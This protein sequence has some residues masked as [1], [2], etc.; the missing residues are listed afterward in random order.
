[1]LRK[2]F[3]ISFL[4]FAVGASAQ[5]EV[6]Y[7]VFQRS[8]FDSNGD[9]AGDLK[10]IQQ[11][12]D[13]LQM[14]GVNAV[15]LSPVYQSDNFYATDWNKTDAVYGSFGE[16]RALVQEAHRRKMKLYQD[17][18]LRF[19]TSKHIWFAEKDKYKDY[20]LL[21]DST[22]KDYINDEGEKDQA[23]SV[24]FKK[25]EV[26]GEI[27]K[28]LQYWIN[29]EGVSSYYS[30]VDGFRFS[31]VSD[32]FGGQDDLLREFW[33][34]VIKGIKDTRADL[35]V[36]ASPADDNYKTE[37]FYNV[38]FDAV[39]DRH[40]REGIVSFDKDKLEKALESS[41]VNNPENKTPFVFVSGYDVGRFANETSNTSQLKAL[42][43]LNLLLGEAA[44]I[45]YGQETGLEETKE[46]KGREF[47]KWDGEAQNSFVNQ[48][49]DKESLWN[50]YK[51]LLQLKNHPA[52]TR[53]K[54]IAVANENQKAISFIRE[55]D[56]EKL[57]IVINLSAEDQRV[58]LKPQQ[59]IKLN[60]SRMLVGGKQWNFKLGGRTTFL[61]P[62][63][64]AVWQ[65]L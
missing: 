31:N 62:Y 34:P 25:G 65:L 50:F 20:L 22:N 55:S 56:V 49:E 33:V 38:V 12:M 13:Y 4:F 53:G 24:N 1:M 16:Y 47:F 40:L 11:K 18:D 63:G 52:L 9:G 48:K 2:I 17:F 6:I 54:Y 5:K 10:G 41:L 44:V 21:K 51:Q 64:V 59:S 30:G 14:L 23:F 37:D 35:M 7:Q 45:Y 58:Y 3:L 57:L 19:V 42:A 26:R 43:A 15:M 39:F 46:S 60:N 32:T 36:I 28:M 61:P 29:P 8:F 27:L